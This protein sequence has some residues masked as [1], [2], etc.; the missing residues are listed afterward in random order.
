[1]LSRMGI[2]I[3]T[4]FADLPFLPASLDTGVYSLSNRNKYQKQKNNVY[5]K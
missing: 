4:A 3:F 1:M 5:G 2:R